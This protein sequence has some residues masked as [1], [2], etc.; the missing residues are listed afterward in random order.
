MEE[1]A[2]KYGNLGSLVN[3]LNEPNKKDPLPVNIHWRVGGLLYPS[4]AAQYRG[5]NILVQ[6]EQRHGRR[7]L[8]TQKSSPDSREFTGNV[9]LWPPRRFCGFKKFRTDGETC[10]AFTRLFAG[11]R[12]ISLGS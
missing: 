3:V 9:D 11:K 8:A 7:P 10:F 12:T 1:L 4:I 6:G 5:V 2:S